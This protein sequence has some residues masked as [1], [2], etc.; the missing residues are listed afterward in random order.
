MTSEDINWLSINSSS[1]SAE[2]HLFWRLTAVDCPDNAIF[3]KHTQLVE[4]NQR[5]MDALQMYHT[6]MRENPAYS[7]KAPAP[8]PAGPAPY[9]SLPP[10]MMGAPPSQMGQVCVSFWAPPRSLQSVTPSPVI[11]T[12]LFSLIIPSTLFTLI[13]HSILFSLIIPSILFSLIIHSILF[14]PDRS[15]RLDF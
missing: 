14:S 10:S 4:L 15:L 12:T 6:L 3:R 13:V 7:F 2:P 5:V 8:G 9:S 1:S 11:H